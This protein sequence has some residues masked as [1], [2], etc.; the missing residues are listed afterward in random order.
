MS[1]ILAVESSPAE[2]KQFSKST[3]N[4]ILETKPSCES[5]E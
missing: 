2:I 5:I 4:R 1:L 3:G